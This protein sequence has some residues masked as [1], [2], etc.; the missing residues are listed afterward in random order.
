VGLKNLKFPSLLLIVGYV[1]YHVRGFKNTPAKLPWCWRK[2]G[3]LK[4]S[5][6][7]KLSSFLTQK[8]SF[9]LECYFSK[10]RHYF[11]IAHPAT[12]VALPT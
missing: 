9:L 5:S 10:F 6:T 7:L 8:F 4:F 12:L 2:P 1:F 3:W 11:F